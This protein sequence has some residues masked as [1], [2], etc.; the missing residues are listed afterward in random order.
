MSVCFF[1][2]CKRH[3][4]NRV[5]GAHHGD[6]QNPRALCV[7]FTLPVTLTRTRA[8]GYAVVPLTFMGCRRVFL[9]MIGCDLTEYYGTNLFTRLY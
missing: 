1:V 5:P 7:P 2:L 9:F 6:P 8:A 4:I 3:W